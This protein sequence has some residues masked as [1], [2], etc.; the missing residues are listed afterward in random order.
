MAEQVR[1]TEEVNKGPGDQ[2]TT[3]TVTTTNDG[4]DV[5]A[6]RSG[7][8]TAQR[9]VWFITGVILT[10]LA[11]R[12][13]LSLLGANRSNGFA[14]FIYSVSYPFVAPFFGLFNYEAQYGVSRVEIETLVAMFFYVVVA[15]GIAQL[16]KIMR[17][18]A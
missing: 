7:Q 18:E 15:A 3:K 2:T 14:D 6:Q 17:K 10:L 5:S 4:E 1:Q 9:I 8:S 12:V 16:I 11:F 13:V